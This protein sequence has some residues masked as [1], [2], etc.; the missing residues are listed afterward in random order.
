M[1]DFHTLC[2]MPSSAKRKNCQQ[3]HIRRATIPLESGSSHCSVALHCVN[4]LYL[5]YKH[6]YY[7]YYTVI[8]TLI[9][10]KNKK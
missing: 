2:I 8:F 9:C 4:P 10:D 7:D 3:H 1:R 6:Y 5:A